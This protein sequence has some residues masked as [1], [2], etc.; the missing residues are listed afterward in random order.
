MGLMAGQ[1]GAVRPCAAADVAEVVVVTLLHQDAAKALHNAST[2]KGIGD[3]RESNPTNG[4]GRMSS[5][6][7]HRGHRWDHRPRGSTKDEEIIVD[8]I[9]II[10]SAVIIGKIIANNRRI[11]EGDQ[12]KRVPIGTRRK[13]DRRQRREITLWIRVNS[14]M[15]VEVLQ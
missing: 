13:K 6:K 5:S 2:T 7:L 12:E 11:L 1:I 10:I 14:G 8:L 3:L 9:I 15:M 4:V